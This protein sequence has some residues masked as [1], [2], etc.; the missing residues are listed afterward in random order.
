MRAAVLLPLAATSRATVCWCAS[1]GHR[2]AE[3]GGEWSRMRAAGAVRT[4][5]TFAFVPVNGRESAFAYTLEKARFG[6]GRC[7]TLEKARFVAVGARTLEE[8]SLVPCQHC[9]Q[10]HQGGFLG[11]PDRQFQAKQSP[12]YFSL[13]GLS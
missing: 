1:P 13:K 5:K 9:V 3:D 6:G 2:R 10:G 7:R 8:A 11:C 4:E 12:K